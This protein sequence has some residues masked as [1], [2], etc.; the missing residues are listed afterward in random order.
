[1]RE[2]TIEI[3]ERIKS[4]RKQLNFS[5]AE[6]A[7]NTGINKYQY[8]D[9]ESGQIDIPVSAIIC[10]SRFFKVDTSMLLTGEKPTEQG[11]SVT[12]KGEGVSVERHFRYKYQALAHNF[13][14]KNGK[15]FIITIDASD[16]EVHF[17]NHSGQEFLYVLEGSVKFY[18]EDEIFTLTEGDNIYFDATIRH[19]V[20]TE[21]GQ[22]ARCLAIV[23]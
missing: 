16:E 20:K 23:F 13:I 22:R 5:I 15:P 8:E 9:Y 21:N 12:R 3:A 1:M 6:V 2:S 11:Y 7:E 17:N 19:A 18:I 14:N 10:I 4:I